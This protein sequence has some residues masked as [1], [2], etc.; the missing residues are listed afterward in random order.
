MTAES[1]LV[2][3]ITATSYDDVAAD[4]REIVRRM[5]LSTLAT[6]VAGTGE[7]GI[8]ALRELLLDR[9]GRAEATSLVDGDRLPAT[10]AALLNGT[11]CRA[12]DFCDAMAPG[13][14]IGSSVVPAALAAAELAAGADWRTFVAA[15]AVGAAVGARIKQNHEV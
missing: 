15:L 7:D 11:M 2:E 6:G 8:A 9:G 14:H 1:R 4:A 5:L 10:S 13:V 3:F 12:L